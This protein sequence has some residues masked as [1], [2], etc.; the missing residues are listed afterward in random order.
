MP[1]FLIFMSHDNVN[2]VCVRDD[3]D[4]WCDHVVPIKAYSEVDECHKIA[5]SDLYLDAKA[6]SSFQALTRS[7]RIQNN[8]AKVPSAVTISPP[9]K[10]N[11]FIKQL[12]EPKMKSTFDVSLHPLLSITMSYLLMRS[13]GSTLLQT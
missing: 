13:L 8:I 6:K 7:E 10:E 11:T 2:R 3:E 1:E 12:R 9:I 4:L 5:S